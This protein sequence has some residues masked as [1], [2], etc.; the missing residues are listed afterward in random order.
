MRTQSVI[1]LA[2]YPAPCSGDAGI[3]EDSDDE[4]TTGS[5]DDECHEVAGVEED[6]TV[7]FDAVKTQVENAVVEFTLSCSSRYHF[8]D[9]VV[10]VMLL[11]IL[12]S[13]LE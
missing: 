4:G 3:P 9:A 7:T 1:R 6:N 12:L 8:T 11:R 5:D 10:L 2:S 13:A